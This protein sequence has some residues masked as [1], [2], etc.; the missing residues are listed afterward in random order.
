[1]NTSLAM[2]IENEFTEQEEKTSSVKLST[3]VKETKG[4]LEKHPNKSFDEI[5][6]TM[7]ISYSSNPALLEVLQDNWHIIRNQANYVRFGQIIRIA[8]GLIEANKGQKTKPSQVLYAELIEVCRKDADIIRV[9]E[10]AP[11]AIHVA[12]GK[13]ATMNQEEKIEKAKEDKYKLAEELVVAWMAKDKNKSLAVSRQPKMV[14]EMIFVAEKPLCTIGMIESHVKKFVA[15]I[16]RAEKQEIYYQIAKTDV[17]DFFKV[18]SNIHLF[19]TEMKKLVSMIREY[20]ENFSYAGND[21]D[22]PISQAIFEL[23][24]KTNQDR[25]RLNDQNRL[26]KQKE[27]MAL[28]SQYVAPLGARNEVRNPQSAR[29]RHAVRFPDGQ[30][31]DSGQNKKK[32]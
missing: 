16:P 25:E 19:A 5:L 15:Q 23:R 12:L 18:N 1:M 7:K 8:G 14:A 21:A 11:A 4:L 2:V 26:K 29:K 13:K 32:K 20:S 22:R 9:R 24:N 31:S 27:L 30:K 17:E 10:M 6:E 3:F 28:G